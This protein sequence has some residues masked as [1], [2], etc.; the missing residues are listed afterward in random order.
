MLWCE[1]NDEGTTI[2]NS[3]AYGGSNRERPNCAQ[4]LR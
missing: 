3:R 1:S 4:T 2:R